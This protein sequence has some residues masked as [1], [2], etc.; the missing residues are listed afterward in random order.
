[1]E[2]RGLGVVQCAGKEEMVDDCRG[3]KVKKFKKSALAHPNS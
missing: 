3:M 2:A 1:M